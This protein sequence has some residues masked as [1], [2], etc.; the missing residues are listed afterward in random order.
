MKRNDRTPN[1]IF[2]N[3]D[4]QRA[5]TLGCYGN[6][7][8]KTPNID[9]L[10]SEGVTFL[11]A[12]C[13]HPLCSPS[14]AT[15]I[16]GEY[17]HSHGLW[18][19][20]TELSEDRDNVVK[21]L[22]ENGYKTAA[23]GKLHLT[24]YHGDPSVFAE[25]VSK[26]NKDNVVTDDMCWKYWKEFNRNYYGFDHVEL[27]IGHGDYGMTGG[28]Y[29]LWIKEN[30]SDKLPLFLRENGLS[31]D[32]SYDAWKSAV[33][34]EIHSATWITDRVDCFLD[35]NKDKPFF[36]SIGF[37]EPHPPF[38]PPKPYC[39]MYDPKD[40]PLPSRKEGEWPDE[41][42]EHILHYFTRANFGEITEERE[43]E[44]LALYYGM[45]SL[46][47]DAVGRILEAVKKYGLE[48]N[49][50]IVF[51]SDHGDW[52]GDHSL[53]L[54]GAVHTRGLTRIP[55]IIKW[56]KVSK[57]GRKVNSVN[58]QLDLAATFYDIAKLKP[59]PTNQGVSLK[60][61]LMGVK[62]SNRDYA[63]IEHRH[64]CYDETGG[65]AN[66]V[67]G[68]LSKEEKKKEA[69]KELINHLD[70]DIIIKT[71]VTDDYRLSYIPA[72]NY[73]ELFDLKT[74]PLELNNLWSK[75][76]ELQNTAINQLLVAIIESTPKCKERVWV[77]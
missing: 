68:H 33:P 24:P 31:E 71:V 15:W 49:T 53:H 3:T 61:I 57:A 19:N 32:T 17:I 38:A 62:E 47:D 52:M 37:Q 36:L 18:R 64:E 30:H 66:N 59:H 51:T 40:M 72:L 55:L 11:N 50:V 43:K 22:K 74:D 25:S 16:T 46:V 10:A 12:H 58:S 2:I 54:K 1:I 26:D 48:D 45:V 9:K 4:Q 65:F 14:R 5:D 27:G 13:T 34:M 44:I 76:D 56:P 35:K 20:G 8:V 75:D 23:I 63:L 7:I 29:G 42:P 60:E 73:G 39:D 21:A 28:H 6:S 69:Q 77:V 67:Y 70:K 41:L